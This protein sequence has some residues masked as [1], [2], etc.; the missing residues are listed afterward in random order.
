MSPDVTV[1]S[2]RAV[3]SRGAH[4]ARELLFGKK[5]VIQRTRL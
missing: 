2:S 5:S 1:S 4:L 3:D